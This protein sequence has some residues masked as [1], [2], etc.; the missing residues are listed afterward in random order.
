MPAV[1]F[2]M[3][4]NVSGVSSK[5]QMSEWVGGGHMDET[6]KFFQLFCMPEELCNEML[7]E[8]HTNNN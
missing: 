4:R 5:C 7:G 6:V 2:E 1:Y 8:N 3:H